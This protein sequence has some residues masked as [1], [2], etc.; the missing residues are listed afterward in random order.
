LLVAVAEMAIAGGTGARLSAHP[1]DIPGHA[2]W[3]G[4]D[5]GRYVLAVPEAGIIIRSAEAAGLPVA[6]IGTSG[7]RDLTL[8]DGATISIAALRDAH[9]RF[10]QSWMG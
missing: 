3:F 8:P 9:A 7:G 10:F 4:E 6:R 2:F 1:R 5:Q